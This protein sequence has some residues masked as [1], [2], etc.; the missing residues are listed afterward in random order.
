[1]DETWGGG[2]GGAECHIY[3]I[4]NHTVKAFLQGSAH[5]SSFTILNGFM[6][7]T[8]YEAGTYVDVD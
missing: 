5:P 8:Q 2:G 6:H 1:M 3:L 7:C 4:R